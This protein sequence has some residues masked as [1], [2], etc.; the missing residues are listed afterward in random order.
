[1]EEEIDLREYINVLIRNWYWIAG[2]TLVAAAAAFVVSSFLPPTYEATAMVVITQPR[3]LFQFDPRVENVPFDP[4]LLSKGYPVLATS[5]QLLQSV[6][7]G[8][9]P[10]LPPQDQSPSRL[11]KILTAQM[12]GDP[13]LIKLTAQSGDPRQAAG[14]ANVWAD[15]FVDQLN[16]IYGGNNDLPLFEPQLAEAR[17]TLEEADYA[18]ADFRGQYGLGFTEARVSDDE[19]PEVV[20][21]FELGIA[22]RLQAKTDLLTEHETRADRIR[23][24]LEEAR[25]AAVGADDTTSPAILAGLLGDMLR[26]GLVD[27]ETNPVVQI[28]LGEIDVGASLAA[29][30]TSLEAKQGSTDEAIARL[31]AEVETLQSELADRQRELDQLLRDREVAQNTYLT[32][33]NKLQEAR[34]EAQYEAGNTAQMLSY[35]AVPNRPASPNRRTN[36]L[37]AGALGFIIGILGVFLLE[38]WRHEG[39]HEATAS[40]EL[41]PERTSVG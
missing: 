21:E 17:A 20:L 22:R 37:V 40:S 26:L 33:S 19:D 30:I 8:I 35:A 24:L 7:D 34:I 18:L 13:T 4:T 38:Y 25:M 16:R 6:A 10:P 12:A 39:P 29:L 9:D 31:T 32:L 2:L 15:S 1:M 41:S 5:D 3:Y 28:N 11:R 36:T 27:A 14:L 23:L